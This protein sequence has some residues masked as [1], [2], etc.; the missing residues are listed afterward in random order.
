MKN[1]HPI[2]VVQSFDSPIEKVWNAITD[3]EQMR[4]WYFDNIPD[5]KPEVGFETRFIVQSDERNFTHIWRVTEVILLKKIGY[6]WDFEEYSGQGFSTFDLAEKG[7]KVNLSL[8]SHVIRNFPDNIPEF[9]RE[10]GQAGWE[11]LIKK[12]LKEFLENE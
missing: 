8:T 5:F 6:T 10:S 1:K 2:I 4:Q 3:V 7:G 9:K 12:S 11:Y